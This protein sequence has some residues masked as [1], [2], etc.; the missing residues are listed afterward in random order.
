MDINVY[1]P[2]ETGQWAKAND[3]NLSRLLR[4]AVAQERLRQTALAAALD[5]EANTYDLTVEDDA[6]RRYTSRLHG[7]LIA[8]TDIHGAGVY[9]AANEQVY[10]YDALNFRLH[11]IP[12]DLL[13]IELRKWIDDDGT[14]IEAMA[15]LGEDAVIDIGAS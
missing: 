7:A 1:L 12:D 9:L 3:L 15:A 14:Y 11:E 4:D 13:A 2:D 10:V 6:G 8:E 5:G